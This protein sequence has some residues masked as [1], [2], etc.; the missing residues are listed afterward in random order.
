MFEQNESA[1]CIALRPL[2]S[3]T[4]S[5]S[6]ARGRCRAP[7]L[8]AAIAA[9]LATGADANAACSSS[10]CPDAATVAA[11]RARAATE[12]GCVLADSERTYLSCVKD[13]VRDAVADGS[14]PS[15]CRTRVV[16]CEHGSDVE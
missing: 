8:V 15:R 12:C 11:V 7:I 6:A 5:R 9:L 1:V 3:G 10:R 4:L 13:F 14:L 16:R 2:P